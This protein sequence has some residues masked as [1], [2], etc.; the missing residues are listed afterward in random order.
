MRW[1]L[2]AGRLIAGCRPKL[3][4]GSIGPSHSTAAPAPMHPRQPLA[5][6]SSSWCCCTFRA[7]C[8]PPPHPTPNPPQTHRRARTHARKHTKKHHPPTHSPLQALGTPLKIKLPPGLKAKD[9]VVVELQFRTA[10]EASALQWLEPSQTAGGKRPYLFTQV[11]KA[12]QFILLSLFACLTVSSGWSLR[13]RRAARAPTCSR[14]WAGF[15]AIGLFELIVTSCSGWSRRRRRVASG[16]TSSRRWHGH[17]CS[18]CN[19]LQFM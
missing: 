10:P 7:P 4:C 13:R 15:C 16:S 14:R 2:G 8:T 5:S 6:K 18:L 9:H 1:L 19:H 11:G 3:N 12:F 17:V